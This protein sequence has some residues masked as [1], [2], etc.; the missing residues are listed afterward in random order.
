MNDKKIG[1]LFGAGAEIGYGMPSGGKFALDIFR[2][3][4]K[5]AKEIFRQ[6]RDGIDNSTQYASQWLPE[7]FD[8]KKIGAFGNTVF[9]TI[10]QDTIGNNREKIINKINYFDKIAEEVIKVIEEKYKIHLTER[11]KNDLGKP[12]EN[13]NINQKIKYTKVFN[14]GNGLFKNNFFAVLLNYYKDFEGFDINQRNELGDIIKAIFQLQLGALSEKLSRNL[15]DNIFEKD[16]LELDIFDDLG[17]NL[18]VNY[19]KAGVKGL[20]LLARDKFQEEKHPIIN[21]A[22]EIIERI[23]ADVLDYKSLI[24]SYWHYLYCPKTEWTKFCKISI[25]LYTV[26]EYI[27]N[28]G[29]FLNDDKIGYYHDLNN[30]NIKPSVIATT[31]YNAFILDVLGK[32]VIFLNGGVEEYYDPY[33]NIMDSKKKLNLKENH[34]IVPLLFTQ[35][36]TKPMTSI[37]MSIKYVDFYNKLKDS[38]FI[39]SV[40]FGFNA[41]DEHINGI[42]RTLIDR[43]NKELYVIDIHG[44]ESEYDRRKKFAQKLKVRN[45]DHINIVTVNSEN[46]K[47]NDKLWIA[48]LEDILNEKLNKK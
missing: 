6:M 32:D 9:E 10:I 2:F 40:G 38:E 13:I 17:G 26:Q 18:S 19:Q 37:D 43:E 1:F 14:E 46:R 34:F 25:F 36:G 5:N 28:Q 15:Q 24:D 27:L 8:S 42:I 33:L 4:S 41:D 3:D 7:D 39:C 48:Y 30:S 16:Q 31:N 23:Y 35:S 20:E 12:Y 47:I 45:S 44:E 11:I 29:K 21:F 22:Y